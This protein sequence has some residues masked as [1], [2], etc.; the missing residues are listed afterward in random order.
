[1]VAKAEADLVHHGA[2]SDIAQ[3]LADAFP[4]RTACAM[5]GHHRYPK[6]QALVAA[7]LE[8]LE[9]EQK[10]A[11]TREARNDLPYEDWYKQRLLGAL[12]GE[13]GTGSKGKGHPASCRTSPSAEWGGWSMGALKSPKTCP[14]TWVE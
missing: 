2:R 14:E 10:A 5:K 7:F 4:H 3:S 6:H 9:A 13:T 8:E 12:D 11:A 1:M